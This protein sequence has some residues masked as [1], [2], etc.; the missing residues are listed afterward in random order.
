MK[1]AYFLWAY[2][3]I[4][5]FSSSLCALCLGLQDLYV[6]VTVLAWEGHPS[7]SLPPIQSFYV[8]CL[9]MDEYLKKAVD[10]WSLSVCPQRAQ[11]PHVE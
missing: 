3:S 4:Y 1:P 2:Y 5:F 7:Q 8:I 11:V 6:I 9:E 10:P